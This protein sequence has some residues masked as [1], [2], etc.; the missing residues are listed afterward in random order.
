[1]GW[2]AEIRRAVEVP[3]RPTHP[4]PRPDAQLGGPCARHPEAGRAP[5]PGGGF[6]ESV[7]PPQYTAARQ[8]LSRSQRIR[9][10]LSGAGGARRTFYRIPSDR[11]SPRISPTLLQPPQ[12]RHPRTLIAFSAA[13]GYHISSRLC[14]REQ[15]RSFPMSLVQVARNESDVRTSALPAGCREGFVLLGSLPRT[16]GRL[17]DDTGRSV[18]HK[19]INPGRQR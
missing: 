16:R 11:R 9:D 2:R 10:G 4:F 6:R 18:L 1:M 13:S 15:G 12:P 19:T 17:V 14:Q 8:P 7:S 5:W 3:W